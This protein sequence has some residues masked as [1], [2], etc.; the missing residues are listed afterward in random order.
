M[1]NY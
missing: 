1:V